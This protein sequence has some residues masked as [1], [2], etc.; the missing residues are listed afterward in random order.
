MS[1]GLPLR[2]RILKWQLVSRVDSVSPVRGKKQQNQRTNISNIFECSDERVRWLCQKGGSLHQAS[3]SSLRLWP[4][5]RGNEPCLLAG[6]YWAP[7]RCSESSRP[8]MQRRLHPSLFLPNLRLL[9][10]EIDGDFAF[11]QNKES[12]KWGRLMRQTHLFS[13]W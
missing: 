10:T 8:F 12:K 6:I 7:T 11:Y 4:A 1:F 9:E 5:V 2:D 13:H 3:Q